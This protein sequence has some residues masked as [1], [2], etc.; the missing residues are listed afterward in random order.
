MQDKIQGVSLA[1]RISDDLQVAT[2]AELSHATKQLRTCQA[3]LKEAQEQS[4]GLRRQ[5]DEIREDRDSAKRQLEELR[6]ELESRRTREEQMA[7][8]LQDERAFSTRQLD[9]WRTEL[10][11]AKAEAERATVELQEKE[12]SLQQTLTTLEEERSHRLVLEQQIQSMKVIQQNLL[13]SI[14]N[15]WLHRLRVWATSIETSIRQWWLVRLKKQASMPPIFPGFGLGTVRGF[16]RFGT[17]TGSILEE[18]LSRPRV[19]WWVWS[20]TLNSSAAPV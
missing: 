18:R 19:A 9:E 13:H 16:A 2:K 12:S 3:R 17:W 15:C 14:Q 8:E 1:Q 11:S 4:D 5:V 10:E 7:V 6:G 20:M